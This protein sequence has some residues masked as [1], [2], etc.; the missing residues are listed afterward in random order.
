MIWIRVEENFARDPKV[1]SAIVTC[2]L[3][4]SVDDGE[5][6]T[7]VATSKCTCHRNGSTGVSKYGPSGS[8]QCLV[9]TTICDKNGVIGVGRSQTRWVNTYTTY[10]TSRRR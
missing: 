3:D 9:T 6:L 5:K 4:T 1:S 10:G 2:D 8:Y 7:A